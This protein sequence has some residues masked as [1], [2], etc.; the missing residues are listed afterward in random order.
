MPSKSGGGFGFTGQR[1]TFHQRFLQTEDEQIVLG[2]WHAVRLR[3]G[4]SALGPGYAEDLLISGGARDHWQSVLR[5]LKN[6][7]ER[8]D[9]Q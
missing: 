2:Q 3:I 4:R 7:R 5:S 9:E 1:I 8:S 6:E